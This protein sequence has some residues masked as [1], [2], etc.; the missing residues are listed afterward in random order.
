[1]MNF[2]TALWFSAILMGFV[3]SSKK[4]K[5]KKKEKKERKENTHLSYSKWSIK[6]IC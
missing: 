1:M 6:W 4:K 3:T 2:T 5:K